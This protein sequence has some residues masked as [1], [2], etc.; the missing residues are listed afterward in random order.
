MNSPKIGMNYLQIWTLHVGPNCHPHPVSPIPLPVLNRTR[1]G[2]RRL[3]KL[4]H[5][6]TVRR[7]GSPVFPASDVAKS[8]TLSSR[9][10]HLPPSSSLVLAL[11]FLLG[12]SSRADHPRSKIRPNHA[13]VFESL[14]PEVPSPSKL[15]PRP[16]PEPGRALPRPEISPC[17][18]GLH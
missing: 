10:R 11:L 18:A 14:S 8:S 4:L 17:T 7:G 12:Q 3:P 6:L 5:R 1:Y 2:G 9:A 13:M 15:P 16:L